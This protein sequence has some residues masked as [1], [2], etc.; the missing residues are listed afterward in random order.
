MFT[1]IV[2]LLWNRDYK[3]YFEGYAIFS[4]YPEFKMWLDKHLNLFGVFMGSQYFVLAFVYSLTVYAFF[5][6]IDT[7]ELKGFN[8]F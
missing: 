6:L 5:K 2:C 1:L 8:D 7:P 3:E 4:Y